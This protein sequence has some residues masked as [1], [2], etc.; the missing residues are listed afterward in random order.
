VIL[1]SRREFLG[2]QARK[3]IIRIWQQY[4]NRFADKAQMSE[5]LRGNLTKR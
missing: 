5:V 2:K 4:L 1:K 3:I